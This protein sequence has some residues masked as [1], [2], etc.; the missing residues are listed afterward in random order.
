MDKK[1]KIVISIIVFLFLV[2]I[3]VFVKI[4]FFTDKDEKKN[5][6]KVNETVKDEVAE[7]SEELQLLDEYIFELGDKYPDISKFVDFDI[8]ATMKI[9]YED[10]EVSEIDKVGNYE[11]IIT[12]KEKEYKSIIVVKDTKKP[13]VVLKELTIK[14]GDAYDANKFISSVTDYSEYTVSFVNEKM[15][16][17]KDVGKYDIEIKVVDKYDNKT[18]S[19]TSLIIEKKS[20]STTNKPSNNTG[21][22]T[23]KPNSNTNNNTSDSNNDDSDNEENSSSEVVEVSRKFVQNSTPEDRYGAVVNLNESYFLVTFSDG[24]TKKENYNSYY[25]LVDYSKIRTSTSEMLPEA[26]KISLQSK[27]QREEMLTCINRYR[28][29]EGV[30]PLVLDETLSEAATVRGLEIAYTQ[31]AYGHNRPDGRLYNTVID[32]VYGKVYTYGENVAAGSFPTGESG[33]AAFKSSA[34]HYTN[35]VYPAFTKVGIGYVYMPFKP[36]DLDYHWV[37]L[38]VG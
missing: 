30:G 38:F 31:V 12:S 22:N 26:K 34:G 17:Y 1:K 2:L 23:D 18:I 4:F 14:V 29:E 10:K 16:K 36:L 13:V 28:A 32:E 9:T 20:E 21:N 15:A 8:K 7:E 19:K 24:T 37:Q 35:M 6:V 5:D 25:Q 11:L 27:K 3:G 33:C